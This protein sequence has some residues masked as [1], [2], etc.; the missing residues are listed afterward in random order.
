MS[1]VQRIMRA[2]Y[3]FILRHASPTI[4]RLLWDREFTSGKW[5]F[6]NDTTGDWSY[7]Y[8]EKYCH[9][10]SILDL[11]CGPGNTANELAANAY[12]EYLGVDISEVALNKA[13]KRTQQN[14]RSDKNHF[15][16]GDMLTFVP[17]QRFD[18][19]LLRESA[20]H[21][22]MG[23]LRDM[24]SRYAQYLKEDGVFVVT[25]VTNGRYTSR[26]RIRTIESEFDV[27]EKAERQQDGSTVLVFRARQTEAHGAVTGPLASMSFSTRSY[28]RKF[29][30]QKRVS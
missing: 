23:Q 22:A 6:I 30:I 11:G 13:R 10:G 16:S 26:A 21:V 24:L 9:N 27:V 20:Y 5:A 3:N 7:V 8:L 15:I 2:P 25:M 28:S 17:T 4:K 18:V 19:I 1:I 14:R 29:E 12:R